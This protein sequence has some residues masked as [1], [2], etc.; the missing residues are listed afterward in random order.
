MSLQTP[1][2]TASRRALTSLTQTR[3]ASTTRR[4]TKL[5]RLPAAPSYTGATTTTSSSPQP[6]LIYNPPSS[7]P[8]VYHTPAKFLPDSDT[9]KRLYTSALTTHTLTSL[10]TKTSPI[11]AVGTALSAP[12]YPL[13]KPSSKLPPAVRGV[14]EKKYHLGQK[15]VEEIRR[16]RE[17]DPEVWTREKL[18]ER[19]GCSQF[20]VGMVAKNAMKA[21]R[22]EGVHAGMRERWGSRRRMAREDRVRRRGLWGR[23]V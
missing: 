3:H 12:S 7:A 18:A 9:R 2:Q 16:L 8:S 13:P 17:E 19:F 5:Q 23:D 15:E 14:Y 1:I 22:V 6:T 10:G 20:F 4:H 11:A 21:E